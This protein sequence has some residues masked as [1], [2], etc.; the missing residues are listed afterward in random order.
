MTTSENARSA[1]VLVV[2]D[3]ADTR[4]LVRVILEQEGFTIAEADDGPSAVAAFYDQKPHLVLLDIEMPTAGGMSV[5][6][7]IRATSR[8]V[9]IVVCTAHSSTAV[10]DEARAMGSSGFVSKPFK[11]EDLVDAVRSALGG[12]WAAGTAQPPGTL[13]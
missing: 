3:E 12:K 13:L 1:H 11:A 5:L 4:F 6:E 9:P 8:D 7:Q 10:S 2:D